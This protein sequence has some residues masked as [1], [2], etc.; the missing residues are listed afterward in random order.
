MSTASPVVMPLPA[1]TV[2]LIDPKTGLPTQAFFD[3][4]KRLDTVVRVLRTEV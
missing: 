2:Q 1:P 4:L 3:Y